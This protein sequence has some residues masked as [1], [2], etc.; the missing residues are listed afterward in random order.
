VE[1]ILKFSRFNAA[2]SYT[3]GLISFFRRREVS[4]K[5]KEAVELFRYMFLHKQHARLFIFPL[6][7]LLLQ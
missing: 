6:A 7:F 3:A 5:G 4:G 2:S 1:V